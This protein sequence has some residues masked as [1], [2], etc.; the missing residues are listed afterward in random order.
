MKSYLT[1]KNLQ[2]NYKYM[3]N[4]TEKEI[5]QFDLDELQLLEKEIKTN[6]KLLKIYDVEIVELTRIK[7]LV[8][9]R[10]DEILFINT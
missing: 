4:F 7:N 1:H 3:L 9:K 8:K 2:T 5:N 10:I 6:E